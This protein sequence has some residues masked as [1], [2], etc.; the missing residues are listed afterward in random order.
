VKRVFKANMLFLVLMLI[1]LI[2]PFL[3]IPI[4]KNVLHLNQ[5]WLMV[6]FSIIFIYLPG[7]IYLLINKQPFKETLKLNKISFKNIGFCLLLLLLMY[8]ITGFCNLLT[9]I[10]FPNNIPSAMNSIFSGSKLLFFFTLAIMP[11]IG[12]EFLMRGIILDGY[13]NINIHVAAIMNG[14]LFGIL[15]LNPTQFL[16]AFMLGVVFSYLVIYTN[17]LFSSMLIHFLFNGFS[18]LSFL[19]LMNSNNSV[20]KQATDSAMKNLASIQ[21]SYIFILIIYG[22]LSILCAFVIYIVLRHLKKI[23]R[24]EEKC[25][26]KEH[27]INLDENENVDEFAS[28]NPRK[29]K[30][31]AYTPTFLSVIVFFVYIIISFKLF[32]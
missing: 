10:W 28:L 9:S 31:L 6:L 12:E 25:S 14:F 22:I 16:Y 2:A 21:H 8:P 15:H 17:S 32:K 24:Y 7:I 26:F 5:N 27:T 23:N 3:V 29:S 1:Q 13:K 30:L 20:T 18:A 11:A 19:F 4:F